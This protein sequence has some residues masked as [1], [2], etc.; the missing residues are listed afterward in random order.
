MKLSYNHIHQKGKR[1]N[2]EDYFLAN[3]E[4][5]IFIVCDGVGGSNKGEEA[6]KLASSSFMDFLA[7]KENIDKT[8]LDNALK[9]TEQTFD[10]FVSENPESN[11][12]ATTLT[13]LHFKENKA[14]IAHCGDSRVYHIRN[15]VILFQTIDHSFVQELVSSGYITAEAALTHPKKNQITRAIQ[16]TRKSTSLD[17]SILEKIEP[18]D[19]FL[20]C[21]DGILESISNNYIEDNGTLDA[22]IDKFNED[23]TTQCIENSND[24][25]TAII[26]KI[27]E[28]S[29]I[30]MPLSAINNKA[31]ESNQIEESDNKTTNDKI[32]SIPAIV[33][34]SDENENNHSENKTFETPVIK[35]N[36]KRTKGFILF[37][38]PLIAGA[39]LYLFF[40]KKPK[41][42]ETNEIKKVIKLDTIVN[43]L[44]VNNIVQKKEAVEETIVQDE[45]Q[46]KPIDSMKLYQA[47][48]NKQLNAI[49]NPNMPEKYQL[50]GLIKLKEKYSNNKFLKNEIIKIDNRIEQLKKN[51]K[52]TDSIPIIKP[53]NTP[54]PEIKTDTTK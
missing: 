25:F 21:T 53:N 45:E 24:N 44:P 29:N 50:R 12:M 51:I 34:N 6:S 41:S 31:I 35:N 4:K 3:P 42:P 10:Q 33:N 32:E 9:H 15:G 38:F 14:I 27:N 1:A 48:F 13:F 8:A 26:V 37:L 2:N 52:P 54:N 11:G 18:N 39:L 23:I 46:P 22:D 5:N 20:L 49:T 40:L 36:S 30:E 7:S 16:G 43:N 47:E 28:L 19:I 17:V